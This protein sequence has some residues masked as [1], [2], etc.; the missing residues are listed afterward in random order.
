MKKQKNNLRKLVVPKRWTVLFITVTLLVLPIALYYTVYIRS[1]TT[2]LTNRDFRQL[3]GIS[4]QLEDRVEQLKDLFFRSVKQTVLPQT[5]ENQ[6]L[7]VNSV[8]NR[9]PDE[10]L[11]APLLEGLF[12]QNLGSSLEFVIAPVLSPGSDKQFVS[13]RLEEGDS[14]VSM[15]LVTGGRTSILYFV[16]CGSSDCSLRAEARTNLDDIVAPLIGKQ[17][18]ESRKGS[19]HREGFDSILIASVTKENITS[20][21]RSEGETRSAHSSKVIFQQGSSDLHIDS[22]DNL[23]RADAPDNTLKAA[24]L[25]ENT[26]TAEVR[27]ADTTYKIYSQP[28]PI[29]LKTVAFSQPIETSAKIDESDTAHDRSERKQNAGEGRSV[30]GK[31]SDT[32]WVVCG[33]VQDS[34]FRREAWA[35]P[36]TWLIGFVFLTVVVALS[37]PFLKLHFI[38]PKDRLKLADIYWLGFSMLVGSA[39]LTLFMLFLVGYIR[40]EHL[41][42][43]QLKQFSAQINDNFHNEIQDIL[44][45]ITSLKSKAASDLSKSQPR[46]D[47]EK[48]S[49]TELDNFPDLTQKYILQRE[50][51]RSGIY[52]Y[53]RTAVWMDKSGHRKLEWTVDAKASKGGFPDRDYFKR[54]LEGDSRVLNLPKTP[55]P[56]AAPKFWLEPVTSRLTAEKIVIVS[57]PFND[58]PKADDKARVVVLRDVAM[59]SLV[60]TVVPPG[61]GYRIIDNS[62]TDPSDDEWNEPGKVLFQSSESRQ[63]KENFFEECDNNGSLRSLVF[64]RAADFASV[65]YKGETHRLFVQPLDGFPNWSLVVFRNEQPLRSVYLEILTVAGSILLGYAVVLLL[66]FTIVYIRKIRKDTSIK[67]IWPT[68]LSADA[69]RETLYINLFLGALSLAVI[70]GV[71]GWLG[72]DNRWMPI[73][74]V[75]LLAVAGVLVLIRWRKLD[76]LANPLQLTANTLRINRLIDRGDAYV[77]NLVLVLILAGMLPAIVIYKVAYNEEMKLFVKH[78]QLTMAQRLA[79][80]HQLVRAQYSTDQSGKP[81]LFDRNTDDDERFIERRLQE[82]RDIYTDFFFGTTRSFQVENHDEVTCD[83]DLDGFM[84]GF[85]R[86]VPWSNDTRLEIGGVT[87]GKAADRLW[88]WESSGVGSSVLHPRFPGVQN[89]H[90]VTQ[91]ERFGYSWRRAW[92]AMIALLVVISY[93]LLQLARFVVRRIFL[94]DVV[95]GLYLPT[96]SISEIKESTFLV[97]TSPYVTTNGASYSENGTSDSKK[98]HYID[99]TAVTSQGDWDKLAATIKDLPAWVVIDHFGFR[100]NDPAHNNQ[101]LQLIKSLQDARKSIIVKSSHLPSDFSFKSTA[102]PNGKG[103]VDELSYTWAKMMTRFRRAYEAKPG[104]DVLEDAVN[105]LSKELNDDK[106][107]TEQD[108]EKILAVANFIRSE[109]SVGPWLTETGKE[110]IESLATTRET[111]RNNIAGQLID[112]TELVYQ[113][114]WCNCS[115]NEKLTLLHLAQ[116]RLLSHNDPEIKPL[117]QRGLIVFL[118]DIRLMNETFKAYVLA[119]CFIDVDESAAIQAAENQARGSSSLEPFKIPILVG[120]VAAVLFLLF[121]QKD[122]ANSS[123]TLVTA[124]TTGIPAVFKLL[125]LFQSDHTGH[126]SFNA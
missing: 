51:V 67:W 120:F 80:R 8:L 6:K 37:W 18:L 54:I 64:G 7:I 83:K 92:V 111:D 75:S 91:L 48:D 4:N 79:E 56:S 125:S 126:K 27:L 100:M 66:P 60:N 33:L 101:K 42:D 95:E 36:Y 25:S 72:I 21:Q 87:Y 123:W 78:A 19:E 122:L 106:K 52:P 14:T 86:V 107:L 38:G 113:R 35:F 15:R 102:K 73:I 26:T 53:F 77:C 49:K 70:F 69:Y 124:A 116:D 43:G 23:A 45:E 22:L 41:L 88:S 20:E 114:L 61:F 40:S 34:H 109:C 1:R 47:K 121:T 46:D 74:L 68:Q 103:E 118:P 58:E 108:R 63:L 105:R 89:L 98:C 93:F 2:N 32:H 12:R 11:T 50:D 30:A 3:A 110:I 28:I 85:S 55:D 112:R 59:M 16:W 13:R 39:I 24:T 115:K 31:L 10:E 104:G 71:P 57:T 99:L 9:H 29:P 94:L 90:I 44:K 5:D 84:T 81:S 65:N 117:M 97:Q 76:W 82:G 17:N 96:F 119:Q 62:G